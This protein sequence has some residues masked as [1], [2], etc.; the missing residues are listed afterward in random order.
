MSSDNSATG[1]LAHSL[2]GSGI[3]W[4]FV[5]VSAFSFTVPFT[6]IAVHGIDPWIVGCGRA[7]VAAVLAAVAL[8]ACRVPRPSRRDALRLIPVA[9]GVV[10]GFPVLTS[11]ALQHTDSAHSAVTIGLLPAGTAVVAVVLTRE[12]PGRMFWIGACGGAIAVVLF[13]VFG[14]GRAVTPGFGD[15]YL[16]GAVALGAVGYAQGALVARDIGAWQTVSWALVLSSPLMATISGVAYLAHPPHAT[17]GQWSAFGY[18]CVVS[19]FLGFFAWYRG[20][21]LGPITTVG[22]TQLVQPVLTVIWSTLILGEHLTVALAV[23]AAAVIGCATVAVRGRVRR[24]PAPALEPV[25]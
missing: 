3:G 13:A 7:V 6:R 10:V 20:L 17:V 15:L 19:A 5:G 8:A 11:L 14:H 23:G 4:G 2:S 9:A 24:A 25:G 22:Q 18:L 16:L 1:P 21:A 12:R